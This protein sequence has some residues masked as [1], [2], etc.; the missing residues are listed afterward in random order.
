MEIGMGWRIDAR[1]WDGDHFTFLY[2][3][4]TGCMCPEWNQRPRRKKTGKRERTKLREQPFPFPSLVCYDSPAMSSVMQDQRA[5]K[6]DEALEGESWRERK[7]ARLI[8]VVQGGK[9]Q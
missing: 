1:K 6:E 9:T 4:I 2:V 5:G 8:K 7:R 3:C